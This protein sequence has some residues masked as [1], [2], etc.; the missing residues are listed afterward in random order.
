MRVR[1]RSYA[2]FGKTMASAFIFSEY[3]LK[4]LSR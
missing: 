4:L 2:V 1:E 3:F